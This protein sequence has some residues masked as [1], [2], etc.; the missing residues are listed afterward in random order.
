MQTQS[1]HSHTP[2]TFGHAGIKPQ[3]ETVAPAFPCALPADL[4]A[5]RP[6]FMA[7]PELLDDTHQ[8]LR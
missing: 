3:P 2:E 6:V 5:L 1:I 7:D 4:A 8:D